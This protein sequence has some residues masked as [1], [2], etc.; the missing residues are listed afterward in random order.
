MSEFGENIRKPHM[1]VM[2]LG[3][4]L[5]WPVAAAV[6]LVGR[7][8]LATLLSAL[9]TLLIFAIVGLRMTRLHE[10]VE[11][12]DWNTV[13]NRILFFFAIW[14][15]TLPLFYYQ[16]LIFTGSSQAAL[17]TGLLVWMIGGPLVACFWT[18]FLCGGVFA[19]FSSLGALLLGRMRR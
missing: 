6:E 10:N 1:W 5:A 4:A 13:R 12:G 11:I 15:I 14:A 17:W 16:G 18:A 19:L 3:F 7:N 2:F 8:G 9:I